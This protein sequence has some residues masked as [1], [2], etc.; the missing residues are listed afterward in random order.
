MDQKE[1]GLRW[2]RD[3]GDTVQYI[4]NTKVLSRS[5]EGMADMGACKQIYRVINAMKNKK[6]DGDK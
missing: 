1:R 6:G 3:R 5:F 2:Q 4:A